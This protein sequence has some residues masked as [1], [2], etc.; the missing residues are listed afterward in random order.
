MCHQ[1]AAGLGLV[2]ISKDNTAKYRIIVF[3]IINYYGSEFSPT[4]I[5]G[6]IN[7]PTYF[8]INFAAV[9]FEYIN[10]YYDS[11][12]NKFVYDLYGFGE[13]LYVTVSD[14][15]KS[16]MSISQIIKEH[17]IE[18]YQ[19]VSK[20]PVF[21]LNPDIAILPGLPVMVMNNS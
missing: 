17:R 2:P 1:G 6:I 19:V 15:L 7:D 3:N 12:T 9:A 14:G 8:T 4:R 13:N 20:Q 11:Q 16:G 5:N 10:Y 18:D 21:N